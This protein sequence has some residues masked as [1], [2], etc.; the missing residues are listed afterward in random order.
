MMK[1]FKSIVLPVIEYCCIIWNPSQLCNI[2]KIESIQRDFTSRIYGLDQMNYWERLLHLKIYSLE[3]RRERYII[4]YVFKT[5]VG[6]VPNPGITWHFSPRRG[7]LIDMPFI[8]SRSSGYSQ[9]LKYNSFFCLAAR[10]FNCL[11]KDV[12]GLTGSVDSIKNHLDKFLRKV[13]DEPRLVG[14]TQ[15]ARS[16]SNSICDQI[17]SR[18]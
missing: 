14:Y 2:R 10:L 12:R 9:S 11:P 17:M 3:R 16:S 13:P 8:S 1:I 7:V 5:I 6:L 15:S 18:V 4:L